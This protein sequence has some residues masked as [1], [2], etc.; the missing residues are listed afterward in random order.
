MAQNIPAL[1]LKKAPRKNSPFTPLSESPALQLASPPSW[2]VKQCP[3]WQLAE[4]NRLQNWNR[5]QKGDASASTCR[6]IPSIGPTSPFRQLALKHSTKRQRESNRSP[7]RFFL[8]ARNKYRARLPRRGNSAYRP[9][10]LSMV[11][12]LQRPSCSTTLLA[13]GRPPRRPA[14]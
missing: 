7:S 2:M 6:S 11:S 4:L 5:S 3:I 8:F 9:L 12:A 13:S 14:A 1:R 10:K